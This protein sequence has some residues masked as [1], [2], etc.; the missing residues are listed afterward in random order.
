MTILLY[1]TLLAALSLAGMAGALLWLRDDARAT[2]AS[3][4]LNTPVCWC[5]TRL[6]PWFAIY[7]VAG[8]AT[9]SDVAT[10]FWPQGLGVVEGRVPYRDFECFFGPLFPCLLALPLLVWKDPRALVLFLSAL[11]AWA[12][13]LTLRATGTATDRAARTRWLV[14]YFLAPGPLLLAVVGG[15]EDFLV[16]FAGLLL[17]HS[18]LRFREV[19]A[20]LLTVIFTLFTKPLFVVPAAALL[21]LSQ[22]RWRFL[23][24]AVPAA[25]VVLVALWA[26]TGRQFLQVL[27]QS[28]NISPP[29][30][31]IWLH[32]LSAG[33]IPIE[34]PLLSLVMVG[35]VTLLAAAYFA[36]YRERITSNSSRYFAAWT[37]IF[38]LSMLL[39]LKSLGAY[40]GYFA[41]PSLA[42]FFDLGD[43]RA[44]GWWLALGTLAPIESSLWYRIDCQLL[45]GLPGTPLVALEYALQGV[46]L[47]AL[48][49]IGLAAHRVVRLAPPAMSP[50][51]AS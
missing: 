24:G 3:R 42:V 16:W 33:W 8:F 48:V 11:E 45:T 37:V 29:N 47:A 39:N 12:A 13:A 32:W 19:G 46:M 34:N 21:G 1:K 44:L 6:L 35:V 36:A 14:F 40:F 9:Q 25:A 18:L 27:G 49:F 5:L 38:V 23:A 4:W 22:R 2:W 50:A 7:V 28:D 43:R 10:A 17:W 51:P 20:G 31:W 30:L 15:Q 26:L 41:L